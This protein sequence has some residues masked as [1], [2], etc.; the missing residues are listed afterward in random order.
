MFFFQYFTFLFINI[1]ILWKYILKNCKLRFLFLNSLNL[2]IFGLQAT[3]ILVRSMPYFEFF[4]FLC[5][6]FVIV[7]KP[8]IN[9]NFYK[10]N[11]ITPIGSSSNIITFYAY[12]F[13]NYDKHRKDFDQKNRVVLHTK[14]DLTL[15]LVKRTS[16]AAIFSNVSETETYWINLVVIGFLIA[17][18]FLKHII[19]IFSSTYSLYSS[20][21]HFLHY[22]GRK[23]I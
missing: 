19:L 11:A 23:K 6:H 13:G 5:N 3:K 20:F 14:I 8:K 16:R 10:Y 1:S 7:S 4:S 15:H 17:K 12:Y 18:V 2:Y 9:L 22:V 21:Y